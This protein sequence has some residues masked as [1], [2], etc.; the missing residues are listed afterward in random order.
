M[1]CQR[2]GMVQ[3][4][5]FDSNDP[6]FKPYVVVCHANALYGDSLSLAAE[7]LLEIRAGNRVAVLETAQK[8]KHFCI[9]RSP[10]LPTN[11]PLFTNKIS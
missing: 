5:S 1:V 11:F 6:A 4:A 7:L 3:R 9:F 8:V 10:V 2:A